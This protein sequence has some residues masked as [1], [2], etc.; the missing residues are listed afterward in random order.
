MR[1]A[2]KIT[3]TGI[4]LII[5]VLG[6][7]LSISLNTAQAGLQEEIGK[8][9]VSLADSTMSE[10]DRT[11]HN[12]LQDIQ[13]IAEAP[14]LEDV[15]T[16]RNEGK[17]GK[18]KEVQHLEGVA[19]QRLNEFSFS[20]GP[21]Q[22]LEVFDNKGKVVLSDEEEE[23]GESL[24]EQ[25]KNERVAFNKVL[26]SGNVFVSDLVLSEDIGKPTVLF[27]AP[28]RD[29]TTP[30]QPITGVV[31]GSFAWQVVEE[32]LQ[33]L[34]VHHAHLY[35]QEGFLLASNKVHDHQNILTEQNTEIVQL[36]KERGDAFHVGTSNENNFEALQA[37]VMQEGHLSYKGSQWVLL[38][39]TPT[40]VAFGSVKK[41][42]QSLLLAGVLLLM[43]TLLVTL[44]AARSISKPITQL[45]E[46][47]QKISRGNFSE[48][49]QVQSRDEIGE[50][51][52]T[53][54]NMRYS[55]KMV[56]NE[57]EKMKGKEEMTRKVQS[58][59]KKQAETIKKLKIAIAEQ[60]IASSAEQKA[61]QKYRELQKNTENTS[62]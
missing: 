11:L 37:H 60:K 27:A 43:L 54:D 50:L 3:V 8:A 49:I 36:Q 34:G 20:T 61:L 1:L 58:L 53:F 18:S 51:A 4:F 52:E 6:S 31:M 41:T 14:P 2:V 55:L 7:M 13:V 5:L 42:T 9:K 62:D 28:V 48:K 40:A 39:E 24:E 59:E 38:V 15:F 16:A 32:I 47:A 57:Y 35:N 44:F 29:E 46:S 17:E 10:I 56:I 19:Q 25:D 12:A 23:L 21:W 22:E 26:S 30:E 33:D 45:Q